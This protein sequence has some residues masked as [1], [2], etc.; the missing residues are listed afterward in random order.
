[1]LRS[2]GSLLGR[3]LTIP[4][5]FNLNRSDP[6]W[7]VALTQ[8]FAFRG[9]AHGFHGLL[10]D[11]NGELAQISPDNSHLIGREPQ[12]QRFGG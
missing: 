8:A 4:C 5:F 3:A 6:R 11:G 7:P 2:D 10:L 12:F 1:M 9:D